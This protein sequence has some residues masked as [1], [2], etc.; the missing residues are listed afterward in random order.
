MDNGQQEIGKKRETRALSNSSGPGVRFIIHDN[1]RQRNYEDD[2]YTDHYQ[3]VGLFDLI[4]IGKGANSAVTNSHEWKFGKNNF[5][6]NM[7]Q[8]NLPL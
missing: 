6:C 3:M 5:N 4:W 8:G 2:I 1:F 7:S